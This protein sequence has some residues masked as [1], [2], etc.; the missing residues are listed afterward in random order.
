M[1]TYLIS[2]VCSDATTFSEKTNFN[3]K[4][5]ANAFCAGVCS[6]F[7]KQNKNIFVK[8]VQLINNL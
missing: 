6:V 2:V 8:R 3:T 7:T 5:E 1:K 4:K